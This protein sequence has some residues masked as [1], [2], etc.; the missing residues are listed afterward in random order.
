MEAFDLD[1]AR[2]ARAEA[3]GETPMFVFGGQ[4]FTLP[5]EMPAEFA[6]L[7]DDAKEAFRFLLADDFDD[8]WSH[9][10]SKEDLVELVAVLGKAYGTSL[11]ESAA[12]GGSSPNGGTPSRPTSPAT[13]RSTSRKP[14]SGRGR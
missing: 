13:T 10:P 12:S 6:Y 11:P 2:A 4:K 14:A 9:R 5:P 8:F 7:L 3:K 1:A